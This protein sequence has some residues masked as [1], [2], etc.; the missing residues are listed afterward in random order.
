M[1]S[2]L[3][4]KLCHEIIPGSVA[5]CML[6][7]LTYYPYTCKPED[8]LKEQQDMGATLAFS[9]VQVSGEYTA[10]LK[11][12][13]WG[14]QID[15][16]GLLISSVDLYDRYR[17]PLFIVENSLGTYDKV[18]PDGSIQDDSRI[19]YRAEHIRAMQD[20]VAL[21]GVALDGV[22]RM[23]YTCWGGAS[24]WCPTLPIR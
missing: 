22:E 24:T 13:P 4:T 6:T 17:L 11:A 21:E 8:V 14:W 16:T 15:L 9:D 18:K 5:G 1:A 3:A 2:A 12:S 19:H 10:Y 20:A 23:G 7:K